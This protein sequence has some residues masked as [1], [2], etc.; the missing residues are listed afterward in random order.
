MMQLI[1]ATL[2][3]FDGQ[4][5]GAVRKKMTKSSTQQDPLGLGVFIIT[6]YFM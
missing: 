4:V 5:L 2:H 3:L 6:L 1:R